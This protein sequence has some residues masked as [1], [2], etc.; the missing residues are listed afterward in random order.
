L[1]FSF[2]SYTPLEKGEKIVKLGNNVKEL[3]VKKGI[4]QTDLAYKIGKNQPSINRLEK[5][6][7]NPSFLYLTEIAEGLEVTISELLKGL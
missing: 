7:I 1:F 6:N 5:G 3:R 2:A 4:S